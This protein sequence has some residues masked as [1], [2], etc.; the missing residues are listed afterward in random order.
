MILRVGGRFA[1]AEARVGNQGP[2]PRSSKKSSGSTTTGLFRHGKVNRIW[3]GTLD[4]AAQFDRS[5]I[6]VSFTANGAS[7]SRAHAG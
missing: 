3:D 4:P 5:Y 2:L 6:G 1:I 7:P